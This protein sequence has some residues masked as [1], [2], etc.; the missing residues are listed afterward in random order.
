MAD[1]GRSWNSSSA[2][3]NKEQCE[4][5]DL[6]GV[7]APASRE[8]EGVPEAV[9]GLDGVFSEDVVG[10]VAVVAGGGGAMTR[11][12]PGVVLRLHHVAVVAGR[13]IVGEVG[14]SLRVNEPVAPE[15][16]QKSE[17]DAEKQGARREAF[18][19]LSCAPPYCKVI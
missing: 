3:E 13:R 14:I 12:Q 5:G 8:I 4:L 6:D 11:F 9:V 17:G 1:R 16:N 10:R 15:T 2:T 19:L 7:G 18:I